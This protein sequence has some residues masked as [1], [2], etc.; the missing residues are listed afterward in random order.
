MAVWRVAAVAALGVVALT[1]AGRAQVPATD[2]DFC[3]RVQRELTGTTLPLVN[4]VYPDYA[5]FKESK[6][7]IDPLEIGQYVQ[8]D[9]ISP[10]RVSCKTKT[11]DHLQE[12]YGPAAATG[13]KTCADVNR[14]IIDQVYAALTEEEKAKLKITRE[15]VVIEPDETVF[16]GSEWVKDYDFVYRGPEAKMHVMGK[17]LYVTWTNIAFRW[18]PERFRGVRYCHLIAP[19]YAKRLVLGE[20]DLPLPAPR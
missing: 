14:R 12:R 13:D 11:T 16:M 20:A 15:D 10:T 1:E 18:A 6:T 5:A 19:E 9:T 8:T 4:I 2:K 3:E 17:S 7:K